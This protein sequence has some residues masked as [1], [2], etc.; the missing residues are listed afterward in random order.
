MNTLGS[1]FSTAAERFLSLTDKDFILFVL[2]HGESQGQ[3]NQD[4]YK[5]LGDERI[6]SRQ[7]VTSNPEMLASQYHPC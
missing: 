4:L 5:E 1:A 3:K 2:R 6:P 7:R